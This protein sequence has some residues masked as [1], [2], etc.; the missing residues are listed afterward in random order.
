MSQSTSPTQVTFSLKQL[1]KK[2]KHAI[3]FGM[4]DNYSYSNAIKFQRV[5]QAHIDSPD[6]QIIIGTFQQTQK[7][8]H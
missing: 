2:F 5:L 8:Y 3:D 7:V 6:T 1:Q 4:S